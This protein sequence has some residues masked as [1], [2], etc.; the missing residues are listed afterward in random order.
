MSATR[1]A[2][3]YPETQHLAAAL[4]VVILAIAVM[5]VLAVGVLSA[6]KASVSTPTAGSA[7]AAWDHGTS[8]AAGAAPAAWDHGTSSAAAP[9]TTWYHGSSAV[10]CLV[11][12]DRPGPL[13]WLQPPHRRLPAVTPTAHAVECVT[14]RPKRRPALGRRFGVGPDRRCYPA[15]GA[16]R[17][18]P[19][20][21]RPSFPRGWGG[22]SAG[23]SPRPSS[24]T[25]ATASCSRP[26]RCSS[27]RRRRTRSSSR[28]PSS[29][30]TCRCSCS[31]CWAA[32]RR[33][34][35]TG[36]RMVIVVNLVRAFVLAILVATIVGGRVEHRRRPG[37]AVHPRD[38]GDVRRLGEQHARPGPRA[39]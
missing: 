7:P 39:A 21:P 3:A 6:S 15:A 14:L 38:R 18:P 25:R 1:T 16:P 2:Q 5:F 33:T 28:W 34:D 12:L 22:A 13:W 4:G 9:L 29:A 27:R 20:S 30:S 35:S 10:P 24:T 37:R 23:C 26:A 32:R 17:S 11:G 31:A 8:A 19:R 36:K